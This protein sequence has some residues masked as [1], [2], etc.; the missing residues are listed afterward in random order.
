M[1][2][3]VITVE[4]TTPQFKKTFENV[5]SCSAP[6]VK[7]RFQILY[8]HAPFISHLE[9]GEIKLESA[10]GTWFFAT[11]GGFLEALNNKVSLLLDTCERADE[12]DVARAQ[13][14]AE[15]ARERL[16]QKDKNIDV[17]RA[18]LALARALNR[19]RVAQRK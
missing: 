11:S 3:H 5:I 7:G 10:E 8:Q 18:Q 17:Q 16:K 15:R 12:I 4:I 13:A 9:V 19:L 1:E 14:A 2:S 6:G